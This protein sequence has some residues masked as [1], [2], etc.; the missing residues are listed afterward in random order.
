ML[1][2]PWQAAKIWAQ[3]KKPAS[4]SDTFKT[5]SSTPNNYSD[6]SLVVACVDLEELAEICDSESIKAYLVM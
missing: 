3:I 6:C 4:V 5:L 1:A 2:Y